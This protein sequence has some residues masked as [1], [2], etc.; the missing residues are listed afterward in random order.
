MI[1]HAFGIGFGHD[2]HVQRPLRKIA[3]LDGLVEVALE[4]LAVA[5]DDL[6][7]LRIAEVLDAL[8]GAPVELD[9][10]ALIVGVDEA[11]GV[12]AEAVHV[13]VAGRDAAFAHDDGDLVQRFRQ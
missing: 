3:A 8:L 10:A 6:R 13:A 4:A 11:V 9:P 1:G 2:L 7:R 5:A 12:R